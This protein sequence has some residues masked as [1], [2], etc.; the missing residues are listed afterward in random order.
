MSQ[1]VIK[2][3]TL[4]GFSPCWP[5]S[6]CPARRHELVVFRVEFFIVDLP[7]C[8]VLAQRN[9]KAI[10]RSSRSGDA[11][12]MYNIRVRILVVIVIVISISDVLAIIHLHKVPLRKIII[13]VVV[14]L[15]ILM[16]I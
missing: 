8:W 12:S 15:V 5:D 10:I 9:I 3:L 7:V 4:K 16:L 1:N 13:M 11:S 6:L 14:V 2:S